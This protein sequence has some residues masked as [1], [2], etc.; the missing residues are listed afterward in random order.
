MY[1]FLA[2]F[3]CEENGFPELPNIY[4][5]GSGCLGAAAVSVE[6]PTADP[7][8]TPITSDGT[9][10]EVANPSAAAESGELS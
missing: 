8:A 6:Q 10:D 2:P 9:T 4:D 3:S 7:E 5:V 1:F